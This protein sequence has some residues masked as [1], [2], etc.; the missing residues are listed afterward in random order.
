MRASPSRVGTC[1]FC[2]SEYEDCCRL[3][4]PSVR[5]TAIAVCD[6]CLDKGAAYLR[7][8]AQARPPKAPYRC[9]FCDRDKGDVLKLIAGLAVFI[10]DWCIGR[11]SSLLVWPDLAANV[12]CDEP[13]GAKC[14]FCDETQ[15]QRDRVFV[16]KTFAICSNCLHLCNEILAEELEHDAPPGTEASP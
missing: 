11:F 7:A 8:Q 3:Q 2:S 10:C 14:S 15:P 1:H 16:R 12:P 9:S 13:P 6:A 5:R 4:I